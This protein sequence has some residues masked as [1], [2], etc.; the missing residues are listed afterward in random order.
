MEDERNVKSRVKIL[1]DE[2][3]QNTLNDTFKIYTLNGNL[4][5]IK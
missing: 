4:K 1:N 2:F 3:K 5:Y